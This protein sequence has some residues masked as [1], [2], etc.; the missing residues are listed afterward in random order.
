[1]SRILY[2]TMDLVIAERQS[3]GATESIDEVCEDIF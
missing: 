3:L 2:E 1:M